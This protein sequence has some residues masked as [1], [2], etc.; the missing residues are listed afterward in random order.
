MVVMYIEAKMSLSSYFMLVCTK[1]LTI[2]HLDIKPAPTYP[3]VKVNHKIDLKT[4]CLFFL[5]DLYMCCQICNDPN[6]PTPCLTLW[7]FAQLLVPKNNNL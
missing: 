4:N 7:L 6:Y 5:R 1:V 3:N 2:E